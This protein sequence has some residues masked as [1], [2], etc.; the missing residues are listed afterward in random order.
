MA[1][2]KEGNIEGSDWAE[3]FWDW[4]SQLIRICAE[5]VIAVA[6]AALTPSCQVFLVLLLL[7]K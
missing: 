2:R 6:I 4:P 3:D 1:T 5:V 7:I